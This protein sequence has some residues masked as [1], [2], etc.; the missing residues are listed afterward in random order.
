MKKRW[1]EWTLVDP[2]SIVGGVE[3]HLLSMAACLE[4]W[5]YDV[6]YSSD[7][8]V[9]FAGADEQGP[10]DVVRTHGAALPKRYFFRVQRSLRTKRV[11]TLHGSSIGFMRGVGESHRVT[12]YK[13]FYREFCGC[14]KADLV[15]SIHPGLFLYQLFRRLGRAVVIWNGWDSSKYMASTSDESAPRDQKAW[16][17]IGRLWDRMKA[18]DRVWQ[19]L[20]VQPSLHLLAIPGEGVPDHARVHKTGRL[21]PGGVARALSHSKGLLL[22]SR[23][24]GLSLVLLEALAAGV[25]ALVTRV[26]GHA[27]LEG[28]SIQGLVWLDRPDD[29]AEFWARLSEAERSFPPEGR[30]ARAR[31]NQSRLWTW[32]HCTQRLVDALGKTT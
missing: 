27:Y 18:A 25:P 19:V 12:H 11:H 7:P 20:S 28:R 14:M 5:G 10:F 3:T 17:F 6:S 1:L 24:E 30:E 4:R 16:A 2:R 32:D 31:H 9:L 8:K 29:P 22:P 13:A 23:Y 21:T 26:G 15:A